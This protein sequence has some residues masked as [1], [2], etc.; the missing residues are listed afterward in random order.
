[1]AFA[2]KNYDSIKSGVM[3]TAIVGEYCVYMNP[4]IAQIMMKPAYYVDWLN[5]GNYS[6]AGT[7]GTSGTTVSGGGNYTWV[8]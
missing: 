5:L 8:G 1:M 2:Y 4:V 7:S 3:G 6:T